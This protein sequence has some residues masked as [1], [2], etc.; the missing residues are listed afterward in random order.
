MWV[1]APA[2][3]GLASPS[4]S[5]STAVAN[6][7]TT[8]QILDGWLFLGNLHT[9]QSAEGL[10][11]LG[12]THIVNMTCECENSFPDKYKVSLMAEKKV[13]GPE[14]QPNFFLYSFLS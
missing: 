2:K 14:A 10:S 6:H 13:N 5:F 3:D 9:A 12:I 8:S 4:V 7:S 11:R 1:W